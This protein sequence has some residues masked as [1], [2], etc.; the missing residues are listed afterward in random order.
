MENNERNAM[1]V[2]KWKVKLRRKGRGKS[3]VDLGLVVDAAVGEEDLAEGVRPDNVVL[4]LADELLALL[5]AGSVDLYWEEMKR[6]RRRD[7]ER[8][9]KEDSSQRMD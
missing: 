7:E 5:D 8:G 9:K 6:G 4:E 2:E 1:K 3:T